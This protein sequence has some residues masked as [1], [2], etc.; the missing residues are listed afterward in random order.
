M[1]STDSTGRTTQPSFMQMQRCI[2]KMK[3]F[4]AMP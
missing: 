1:T 2:L 3:V 4:K